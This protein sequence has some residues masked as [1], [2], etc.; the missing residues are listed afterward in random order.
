METKTKLKHLQRE[1]NYFHQLLKIQWDPR[2][3]NGMVVPIED[4]ISL[5]EEM[6]RTKKF[7]DKVSKQIMELLEKY[8][9]LK[10]LYHKNHPWKSN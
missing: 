6:F 4:R 10:E 9:S 7:D 2:I 1:Y 5:L 8:S 3:Y